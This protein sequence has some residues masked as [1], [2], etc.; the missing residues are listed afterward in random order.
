MMK[1]ILI[2]FCVFFCTF[3]LSAEV[4]LQKQGTATRLIVNGQPMLVLGGEL[5]NSAVTSISD[6]DSVLPRMHTLG[7]NTVF[8]PIY[9]DLTEPEEGRFNFSLVDEEI[10]VARENHLKLILLWFGA[11]KNSMSCC[12]PLW[13]KKDISR[14]PRAMTEDGKSLEIASAFSLHVEEADKK[15]FCQ[16]MQHLADIDSKESTVIMIQ[17]ENEIGMLESARDHSPLAEKVFKGGRW[18]QWTGDVGVP[19]SP[20]QDERFQAFYYARYVEQLVSAGKEIL[21][22]PMYVNAAMNS[23][24]RKPG[25]YPS[26]G[27]LAHLLPIWKKVAPD[28]D[29]YAP[30]IYDTGFK[31]W[32]KQYKKT[33]NPFFTPETR[34]GKYSGVRALYVFG[35]VDAMGFSTFALDQAPEEVT[36]Y[37]SQSYDL[38]RQLSP[39]LLKK[40]GK[41][42]S[43]GVLFNQKDRERIIEDNGVVLIVRHYYTLP[44]DSRAT[45]GSIWPEGGG[46]ILKL[47]KYDYLIAGSG[48]VVTFQTASEKKQEENVKRGEDGFADK[49]QHLQ[50]SDYFQVKKFYGGRIGIGYVDQV[51]FDKL[52]NMLFVRRDNGDQDHQG[53]HARI[54]CDGYKIL[55]VKLYKY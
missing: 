53:R 55:H 36:R 6:I 29:I 25:E 2:L 32:V 49:G 38:L 18:R 17:V 10:K 5:S 46:L 47:D 30:D 51:Q 23:R 3:A 26:A 4:R 44:W 40:Q 31:D 15:A 35:E 13:F 45:D 22:I 16:L 21:N 34:L 1:R 20:E 28:I 42:L 33:D 14:F 9:W 7:L 12:A 39:L 43:W 54:S 50:I 19:S 52:G 48:I 24:G 27:P 37:V 11:W 8:V 41:G